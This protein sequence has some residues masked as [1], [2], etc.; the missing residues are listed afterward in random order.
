MAPR[1]NTARLEDRGTPG[2][3]LILGSAPTEKPIACLLGQVAMGKPGVY[4]SFGLPDSK[5]D[6]VA[7]FQAALQDL[8]TKI[9]A[10]ASLAFPYKIG[11]GLAGGDWPTYT[12]ILESWV[13]QNPG[14]KVVLYKLEDTA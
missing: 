5:K 13:Q 9:P 12:G 7:Y 10:S 8:A 4:E 14:F 3:A 1:R 6:R 11:C 2:T